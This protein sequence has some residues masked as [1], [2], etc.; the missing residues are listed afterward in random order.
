ME[1]G[2]ASLSL[3]APVCTPV[4]APQAAQREIGAAAMEGRDMKMKLNFARYMANTANGLL[5]AVFK[6]L[7]TT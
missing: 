2:S 6:K 3:G 4:A 1:A 7:T 5:A